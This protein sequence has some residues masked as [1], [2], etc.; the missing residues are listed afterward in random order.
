MQGKG[1]IKVEMHETASTLLTCNRAPACHEG[2]CTIRDHLF[3][4]AV[5]ALIYQE[6][7]RL[8]IN[9]H[10]NPFYPL[11]DCIEQQ[12]TA[13]KNDMRT[14]P[15]ESQNHKTHIADANKIDKTTSNAENKAHNKINATTKEE[16]K[17]AETNTT[18]QKEHIKNLKQ[19]H[20]EENTK[21]GDDESESI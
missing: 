6:R 13:N 3:Y 15:E 14:N 19:Q 21:R 5:E 16:W 18:K 17:E 11:R 7:E 9:V 2:S 10:A 8:G 1:N 20:A 4:I 12:N